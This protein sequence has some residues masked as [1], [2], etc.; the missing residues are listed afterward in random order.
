MIKKFLDKEIPGLLGIA[1]LVVGVIVT[2]YLVKGPSTFQ[3][4]ANPENEPRNIQI[5]NITDTTFSVAYSTN[6]EVIGTI[7]YGENPKKLDT[8]VLDERDQLNQEINEYKAHLITANNLNPDTNYYFVINSD[9]KKISNNGEPF[10]T[11]T[12]PKITATPT[13]Q[14]PMAG[15]VIGIDGEIVSDGLVTVN[16][17]GAQKVSGIVKENGNYT[18]PLN[19]L[20]TF[21][22]FNYMTLNEKSVINIKIESGELASTLKVTK[23]QLEPVP[24]VTLTN[25]YDFIDSSKQTSTNSKRGE[26]GFPEFGSGLQKNSED[27]FSTSSAR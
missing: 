25:N 3:I 21:D 11:K 5:T 22:L 8:V 26:I 4:R 2:T 24:I 6:D 27:P 1:I 9:G 10:M 23:D 16:I 7:S 19:N 13:T 15:R 12:G 17:N 18:I 20:R 14:S